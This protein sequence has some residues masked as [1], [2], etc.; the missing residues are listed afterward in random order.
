MKSR[1]V[2]AIAWIA[3]TIGW[4]L[5]A[6]V[7]VA[8]RPP[9]WA[10]APEATVA[11]GKA[12]LD[13]LHYHKARRI[14]GTLAASGNPAAEVWLAYMDERGL[15]APV[16]GPG[17]VAQLTKAA[18][19]GS[20]KAARRLGELYLG[21]HV[22]LQDVGEARHWLKLAAERG[23]M[24]AQRQLGE[25]Y[26]RGLGVAQDPAQ[27]YVWLDIAASQG[28]RQAARERDQVLA[29]LPPDAVRQAENL[30]RTTLQSIDTQSKPA[31]PM[32]RPNPAPAQTS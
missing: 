28:D 1:S 4:V 5:L 25:I 21:G 16:N 31:T 17:A 15:G 2:S 9:A 29:K 19:G 24:P 23:D 11:S 10:A 13:G 3:V 8:V 30:A 22:V 6:V 12:A 18:A 26:A 7:L 32:V 27:G 14:F 20:A